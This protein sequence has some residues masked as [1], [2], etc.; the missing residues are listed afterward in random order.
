MD[1][2]TGKL[3]LFSD[4][5]LHVEGMH[6]ELYLNIFRSWIGLCRR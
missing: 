1:K 3:I 6:T 5:V 4:F 2:K